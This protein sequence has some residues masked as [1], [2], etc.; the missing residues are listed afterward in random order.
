MDGNADVVGHVLPLSP[1]RSLG[2]GLGSVLALL[3]SPRPL[4]LT[5]TPELVARRY[6]LTPA[7]IDALMDRAAYEAYL[8]TL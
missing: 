7:E 4:L 8:A 3:V 5:S 1:K 6:G 2:V